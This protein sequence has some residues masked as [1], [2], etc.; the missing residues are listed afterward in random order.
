MPGNPSIPLSPGRPGGPG[1]PG[2]PLPGAAENRISDF[3]PFFFFF[4]SIIPI[5]ISRLAQIHEYFVLF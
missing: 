5:F 2:N 1:I 3:F 4:S